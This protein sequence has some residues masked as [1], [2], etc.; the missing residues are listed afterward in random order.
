MGIKCLFMPLSLEAQA[1]VH[2]LMF[3]HTN[4]L[5]SAI[6]D[7][8]S[9]PTQ[10]MHIGL[11][12]LTSENRRGICANKYNTRN[13]RNFKNEWIHENDY[14]YTKKTFF[15]PLWIRWPLDQRV[16]SSREAPIEVH[17]ESLGSY[18]DIYEHYLVVRNIKKTNSLYI[19]IRTIV[20]HISFYREIKEAIQGFCRAH[21]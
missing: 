20:G 8:I 10:D 2:L 1:E 5:S 16:I 11:Y 21:S 19:Y 3:S 13:C 14:K 15:L 18:H 4:I 12:I 6:G 17:Y 7:L 9:R